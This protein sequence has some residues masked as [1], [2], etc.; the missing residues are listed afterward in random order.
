MP[1]NIAIDGPVGAGKSSIAD[2]V[3]Q[4]LHILHLD[5]GAMYRTVALYMLR[6]GIDPQDE[7][8]V[9]AHCGEADVRVAYRD[10][11]QRTMLGGEDV[12]DL[13][14]TGEVSAA[15]SAISKWPAVRRRM[16]AAQREIAA[17]ADMLIDGRDIGTRVLIDAPVKI[18]LTAT[19]EERARRRYRQQIEKG[20]MTPYEQVLAELN[21]RDAQDMNRETDP[22]RQPGYPMHKRKYT[23]LYTIIVFLYGLL[24]KLLFFMKIEGRENVPK[25]RNCILMGNHQCLLDP[26]TLALCV[27]DREIHFMGK[28]ELFENKVLG[29]VFRQVHGFPV[30][31]G[32][33]DMGAIRTAM[34]VLKAGETLGIF[35]EGTRSKSGH[36]LPLLGGASLLALKSGCDVVPVYIEGHYKPFRR[37]VVHVGKPIEMADLRAGRMNKETC[38]ALTERMEAAFARLSGGKSLPPAE[39]TPA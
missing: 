10:G 20:D 11:A 22:L 19:P 21:A 31:R 23:L 25:D 17:T 7:Q 2:Q 1:M 33:M 16:V 13:I 32:N 34:G 27:P 18:F 3:A 37:M 36:M 35:P 9:S 24:V 14:R 5:T 26:V 4:R 28:K 6:N 12:S 30:D 8:T 15:A 29:W 38:D 39:K